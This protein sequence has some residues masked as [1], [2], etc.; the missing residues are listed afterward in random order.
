MSDDP[1]PASGSPFQ[2]KPGGK[3][4]TNWASLLGLGA[5]MFVV[6]G[7]L[8]SIKAD[9]ATAAQVANTAARDASEARKLAEDIRT[10]LYKL[11]LDIATL[12]ALTPRKT[13][14]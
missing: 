2:F 4:S 9:I 5:F 1:S 7:G 12:S 6:I 8:F 3:V 13:L 14:P 11:R 10:D